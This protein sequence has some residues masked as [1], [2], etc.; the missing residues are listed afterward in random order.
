MHFSNL[1]QARTAYPTHFITAR[2]IKHPNRKKP[3]VKFH[4]HQSIDHYLATPQQTRLY[5]HE[6][7]SSNSPQKLKFDIDI[8]ITPNSSTFEALNQTYTSLAKFIIQT[9]AST[10]APDINSTNQLQIHIL[11][12]SRS[13][14]ISLHIITNLLLD[15]NQQMSNITDYIKTNLNFFNTLIETLINISPQQNSDHPNYLTTLL[16]AIDNTAKPNQNF[17]MANS[18]RSDS[19]Y[20]LILISNNNVQP[21]HLVIQDNRDTV[22]SNLIR[23][24]FTTT[25]NKP[26]KTT[27]TNYINND[28]YD[29]EVE[30]V[31]QSMIALFPECRYRDTINSYIN[32]NRIYPSHCKLCDRIHSNDNTHFAVKH[33]SVWLY[34]CRKSDK[35]AVLWKPNN[36]NDNHSKPIATLDNVPIISTPK[37]QPLSLACKA[38]AIISNYLSATPN[39]IDIQNDRTYTNHDNID[40]VRT[41]LKH[42]TYIGNFRNSHKLT[43]IVKSPLGTGKTVALLNT[44]EEVAHDPNYR[45]IY[46]SF[47][48]SYS[49]DLMPKL[50]KKNLDFYDYR[51]DPID[52][53]SAYARKNLIVQYNSIHHIM[54]NAS[55]PK[56][57]ILITDEV[58]SI[59][60]NVF[61][62]NIQGNLSII[63]SKYFKTLLTQAHL[64]VVLDGNITNTAVKTII[65]YRPHPTTFYINTYEPKDKTA[66][67]YEHIEEF[68]ANICTALDQNKKIVIPANSV[69]YCK[70]IE[71]FLTTRYP[72][73]KILNY[74]ANSPNKL[75]SKDP[76]KTV[77]DIWIN[78]DIL[79]YSPT[80]T[81]GISFDPIITTQHHFDTIFCHFLANSCTYDVCSQMMDRV[82]H[83]NDKTIHMFGSLHI[84]QFTDTSIVKIKRH[85]QNLNLQITNLN[86]DRHLSLGLP[87]LSTTAVIDNSNPNS[88]FSLSIE[89][90]LLFDLFIH[91]E[92]MRRRSNKCLIG[93]ILATK[94]NAIKSFV[95]VPHTIIDT[96]LT[97]QQ[98]IIKSNAIDTNAEII[99]NAT[100][101]N[102]EDALVIG[103]HITEETANICKSDRDSYEKFKFMDLYG[104]NV[105]QLNKDLYLKFSTNATKDTFFNL[106]NTIKH[107]SILGFKDHLLASYNNWDKIHYNEIA[108]KYFSYAFLCMITDKAGSTVNLNGVV[109]DSLPM[110]KLIDYTVVN[111]NN[112]KL[113]EV[114]RGGVVMSKDDDLMKQLK[115]INSFIS[116]TG[117]KI[118]IKK[119]AHRDPTGKYCIKFNKEFAYDNQHNK[120]HIES[121]PL[122]VPEKIDL[123]TLKEN[124]IY[125]GYVFSNELIL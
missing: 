100:D 48:C 108:S 102:R 60:A 124:V 73:K 31:K 121:C 62:A 13:N 28:Q 34:K 44:L 69:A 97:A 90:D 112:I 9:F 49:D 122:I 24:T 104:L 52:G 101:L 29:K 105:D 42:I 55:N 76:T 109:M 113:C 45:I 40:L 12:A 119:N 59:F 53:I 84:E 36:I 66:Y 74:Y 83:T 35:C 123:N 5:D 47:R 70:T 19:T 95:F 71:T 103:K 91:R 58:E 25:T 118:T 63:C 68:S 86:Q 3:T 51:D 17:R 115:F 46:V 33:E 2:H 81:A 8:A 27:T 110:E 111:R 120:F 77:N 67:I 11:S 89:N 39:N 56:K 7:I 107:K 37:I 80:I 117:F 1:P 65:N 50:N 22:Q 41:N 64:Y 10:Q 96:P 87:L 116:I 88:M 16:N 4:T 6:V 21:F 72:L 20:P 32:F 94:C 78:C 30:I 106:T 43:I 85:Y 99:V 26:T 54:N 38:E 92:H 23:K 14:K 57:L 114:K 93:E 15:N 98:K 125:S 82:R 61:S 18:L 79:I 75:D